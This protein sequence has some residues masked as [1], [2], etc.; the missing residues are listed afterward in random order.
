MTSPTGWAWETCTGD[1]AALH[2]LGPPPDGVPTARRMLVDRAAMV[3]G[4]SQRVDDIDAKRATADGVEIARRRSGGGAVLLIPGE[5]L[6][7]DFWVPRSSR[8]WDD[9]VITAADWLGDLWCAVAA[10]AGIESVRPH[11]GRLQSTRWS[12]RLCFAGIGPGEVLVG[13]RKLVGISQRRTRDWTRLQ[14]VVHER[15]HASASFSLL[16]DRA[17]AGAAPAWDDRVAVAPVAALD[18]ALRVLVAAL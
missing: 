16:R 13:E 8:W 6:W 4:S 3:L 7:V 9:D 17:A 1:A 12:S 11:R 10:T 5:H 15:W 18:E 2:A 14:S